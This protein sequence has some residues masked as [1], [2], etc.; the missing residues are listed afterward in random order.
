MAGLPDHFVVL[1]ENPQNPSIEWVTT[2][3]EHKQQG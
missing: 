3:N 2:L 1:T